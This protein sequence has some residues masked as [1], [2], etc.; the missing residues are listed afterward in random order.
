MKRRTSAQCV[1]ANPNVVR[2][3][4]GIQSLFNWLKTLDPG[5][6]DCVI[7]GLRLTGSRPDTFQKF[8]KN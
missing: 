7:I 5:F 8:T 2:V 3:Q 4:A 1:S 6:R